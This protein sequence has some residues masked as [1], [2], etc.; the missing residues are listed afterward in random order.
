MPILLAQSLST[1][2]SLLEPVAAPIAAPIAQ[3]VAAAAVTPPLAAAQ[4]A[5]A[6]TA[7]AAL[8]FAQVAAVPA[9]QVPVSTFPGML[10]LLAIPALLAVVALLLRR[11]PESERLLK[12]IET[13][14]LGGRR[15][16]ILAQLGNEALLLASSEA[17][18]TLLAARPAP[19][20]KPAQAPQPA[21]REKAPPAPERPSFGRAL[22]ER[23][24]PPRAPELQPAGAAARQDEGPRSFGALLDETADDQELRRKLVAGRRARVS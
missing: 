20:P 18:V 3:A 21:G 11:R 9:A 5:A 19:Q 8:Q 24:I 12:I 23:L 22:L 4:A 15:A 6:L 1:A 7:P 16:L 14:S 2:A 13:Q 10:W 17:G